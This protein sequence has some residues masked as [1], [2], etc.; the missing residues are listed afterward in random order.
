LAYKIFVRNG[1]VEPPEEIPEYKSFSWKRPNRLIQ[2]D[3]TEFNDVQILTM[4]DDGTR[5]AWATIIDDVRAI[6]VAEGMR[7]LIPYKYDNIL[8]DNGRQF[9]DTN[10][11]MRKYCEDFIKGK[12]IHASVRH[13]QTLGKLGAYQKGLKR[14]LQYKLGDS[15]NKAIIRPLIKAYNHF[16]NNGRRHSG[17]DGIPED[18]YSGRRDEKWYIKMMRTL[19]SQSYVPFFVRG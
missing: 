6:T 4:E 17:I 12:H 9:L 8:T 15:K 7:E 18:K 16:Y 1:L 2:S 3:I 10:R 5:K 13:P 14:F 19:K 11:H